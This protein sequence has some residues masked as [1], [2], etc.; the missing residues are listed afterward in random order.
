ML[1]A[2]RDTLHLPHKGL[3]AS[4]LCKVIQGEMGKEQ[5]WAYDFLTSARQTSF[6]VE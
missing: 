1:P 6:L 3:T 4:H 5:R 2:I